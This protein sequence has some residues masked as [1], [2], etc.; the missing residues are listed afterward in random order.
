MAKKPEQ[1]DSALALA[2]LAHELRQ[3]LTGIRASAQLLLEARPGDAAVAA[4]VATIVQQVQRIQLIVERARRQGAPPPEAMR[5]DVNQAVDVAWSLLEREA[6]QQ[7]AV[8]ERDLAPS[9]PHVA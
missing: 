9:L 8:L 3:P 1:K 4:R 2:E 6:E 5:A 7:R